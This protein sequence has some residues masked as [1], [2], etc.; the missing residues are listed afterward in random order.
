MLAI[1]LVVL[2]ISAV[3][4]NELH[5]KYAKIH[6]RIISGNPAAPGQFPWQVLIKQSAGDDVFCGGSIISAD[7]VLTAGHCVYGLKSLFLIFGA[8]NIHEQPIA[9]TSTE[10]FYHS[11]YNPDNLNN[12]IAAVK[13]PESLNFNPKIQPISL[14][15]RAAAGD[16]FVGKRGQISGWGYI[17]D[18][19]LE[20][21]ENLLFAQMTVITNKDCME[22]FGESH[23]KESTLCAQGTQTLHE[24]ICSG[25]SGGAFVI[26]ID[27][28]PVQI[29]INSFV[30]EQLCAEG[31][32][33][34]FAR[35]GSF[36][37]YIQETT[38]I[39]LA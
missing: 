26:D 9:L 33:A 10:L 35:V 4:T 12:D 27:G 6:P 1:A 15:K 22:K 7:W 24:S 13:L 39:Q 2:L 36:L 34:G 30:A 21:S 19:D 11:Q 23:V 28:R 37:D 14:V 5:H 3:S 32:P 17:S 25:D 8:T 31:Y 16:T 29:G 38:G 20:F 18:E